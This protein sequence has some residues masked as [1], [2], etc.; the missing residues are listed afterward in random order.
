MPTNQEE[1]L[2]LALGGCLEAG[3]PAV[4]SFMQSKI[5]VY[6]LRCGSWT[7]NP[8]GCTWPGAAA[9]TGRVSAVP[10]DP[11]AVMVLSADAASA[12]AAFPASI[13][14]AA[15][16]WAVHS[17][18]CETDSNSDEFDDEAAAAAGPAPRTA[19]N[20]DL[21]DLRM[22]RWREGAPLI[23]RSGCIQSVSLAMHE[24]RAVAVGG[25]RPGF[26]LGATREVNAYDVSSDAWSALPPLPFAVCEAAAVA[27]NVPSA[28]QKC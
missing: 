13:S 8:S 9:A 16:D 25:A 5:F 10:L 6:D 20:V 18:E 17:S 23:R 7:Q 1:G 4:F 24:G 12:D 27:V 19:A 26:L 22:W 21:L 3:D 14:A 15:D 2:L 11:F 28:L